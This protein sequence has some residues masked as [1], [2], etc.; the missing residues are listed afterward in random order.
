MVPDLRLLR[1]PP[2]R[3]YTGGIFANINNKDL[4]ISINKFFL[5]K[6]KVNL[7]YRFKTVPPDAST[8]YKCLK[9][10]NQTLII[11]ARTKP[12]NPFNLDISSSQSYVTHA[13]QS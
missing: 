2:I 8:L 7:Y 4:F 9:K 12:P 13:R 3:N 6:K 11:T 1:N 10:D 5:N